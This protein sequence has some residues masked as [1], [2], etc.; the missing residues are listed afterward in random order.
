MMLL[1]RI[2]LLLLMIFTAG[3]VSTGDVAQVTAPSATVT[4]SEDLEAFPLPEPDYQRHVIRLPALEDEAA[5][6][7][8]LVIGKTV[9]TDSV[10]NY[11]L[12]G[13]LE[14]VTVEGWGY[15]YYQLESE[16]HM[17]GTLMA[18]NPAAPQVERFVELGAPLEPIRYNSKVPIVVI[19]P[20]GFEV[21]YQVWSAA[22]LRVAP[23]G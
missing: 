13:T 14:A 16:G 1:I 21:K 20:E 18:V 23:Q 17:A 15:T 3:C 4:A 2:H 10:N 7:V 9:L 12:L 8:T 6:F 5:H 22:E 19:V 11:R